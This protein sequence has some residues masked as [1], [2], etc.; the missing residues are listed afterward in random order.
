MSY[1]YSVYDSL[2]VLDEWADR[3]FL[4]PTGP[5]RCGWFHPLFGAAHVLVCA[6]RDAE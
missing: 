1:S 3:V 2:H 5:A 4:I 6:M